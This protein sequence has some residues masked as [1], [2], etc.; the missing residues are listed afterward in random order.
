M[1]KKRNGCQ[2]FLLG[3]VI[4]AAICLAIYLI[5]FLLG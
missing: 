2:S 4:S 3:I 1:E 5:G